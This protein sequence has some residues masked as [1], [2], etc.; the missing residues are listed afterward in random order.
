MVVDWPKPSTSVKDVERFLGVTRTF[1]K[2]IR[3]YGTVSAPIAN[4]VERMFRSY[5][6]QNAKRRVPILR[7]SSVRICNIYGDFFEGSPHFQLIAAAA[8][9]GIGAYFLQCEKFFFSPP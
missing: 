6:L 5:G 3:G 2:Y 8:G 1:R 4:S 9:S 7:K